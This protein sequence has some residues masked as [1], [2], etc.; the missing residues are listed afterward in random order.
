MRRT[1]GHLASSP[2]PVQ[3][4]A[5][6]LAN[7]GADKRF[8]FLRGRWR[9]AWTDMKNEARLEI[10]RK[11]REE[12][13]KKA[14]TTKGGGSLLTGLADYGDSDE[15][16]DADEERKNEEPVEEVVEVSKPPPPE[17]DDEAKKEARR[18]RAREWAS[19]RR[20]DKNA[21]GAPS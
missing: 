14:S 3:L 9:N 12:E 19:K 2:N 11:K 21:D 5:R 15:D 4:E 13:S 10:L 20:A 8:A 18:A 17:A 6:I 16:S 7:H 1:A